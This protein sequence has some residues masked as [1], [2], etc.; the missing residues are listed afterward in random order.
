MDSKKASVAQAAMMDDLGNSRLEQL[1]TDDTSRDRR[2]TFA[3]RQQLSSRTFRQP[4]M[5][6]QGSA[7]ENSGAAR[8]KKAV[9]D[10]TFD[11]DDYRA[12]KGLDSIDD[13]N[14]HRRTREPPRRQTYDPAGNPGRIYTTAGQ[15][16]HPTL[17]TPGIGRGRGVGVPTLAR[18]S[19]QEYSQPQGRGHGASPTR[20]NQ[21]MPTNEHRRGFAFNALQGQSS[22]RPGPS[23]STVS[24]GPSV[25]LSQHRVRD[26]S[27][28]GAVPPNNTAKQF[29]THKASQSE[30]NVAEGANQPVGGSIKP[31]PPH[32][33]HKYALVNEKVETTPS[34]PQL[35]EQ[36]REGET[37]SDGVTEGISGI[38]SP[39]NDDEILHQDLS[40]EIALTDGKPRK[41]VPSAIT[42]YAK[43][44]IDT[45]FWEI[46]TEDVRMRGDIRYCIRPLITGPTVYLRRQ[47]GNADVQNSYIRFD[48]IV[49]AADFM[50]ELDR[51]RQQHLNSQG[52][53]FKE[54]FEKLQKAVEVSTKKKSPVPEHP[55]TEIGGKAVTEDF[56]HVINPR[57]PKKSLAVSNVREKQDKDLLPASNHL[58]PVTRAKVPPAV[59]SRGSARPG[60]GDTYKHKDDTKHINYNE[61]K[62]QTDSNSS[63][64][65]HSV[66]SIEKVPAGKYLSAES[67][68]ILATITN[69]DYHTMKKQYQSRV[70][71]DSRTMSQS[72]SELSPQIM[73][74]PQKRIALDVVMKW[75]RLDP[76]FSN[77]RFDEQKQVC[78]V[79][80]TNIR[81]GKK[82]VRSVGQLIKLRPDITR[83]PKEV[84]QFNTF[85]KMVGLSK[86][87]HIDQS[88]MDWDLRSERIAEELTEELMEDD[89]IEKRHKERQTR[90]VEEETKR[91]EAE[92]KR[93]EEEG[94]RAE[95]EK[96]QKAMSIASH[97]GNR[98]YSLVF[99]DSS[100]DGEENSGQTSSQD[101]PAAD[102][103]QPTAP[104]R[105]VAKSAN[106]PYHNSPAAH[107]LKESSSK[108]PTSRSAPNDKSLGKSYKSPW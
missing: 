79:A 52:E 45:V 58:T 12:V 31:P 92:K 17:P 18:G 14:A 78:A 44:N 64:L 43:P 67:L 35:P 32:I 81:R 8:W 69:E 88:L 77:L 22:T 73:D 42:L 6:P 55:K 97:K 62:S 27:E 102:T 106:T 51:L 87:H 37:I 89:E 3:P 60:W 15:G 29:A 108:P 76:R 93:A 25:L 65:G 40:A 75:M 38:P 5:Q 20:N 90:R 50:E 61:Q 70:D 63:I 16:Q 30:N 56:A 4:S 74:M 36:K 21:T 94:K 47:E 13:G 83:C 104:L 57:S 48:S 96:A 19:T 1:V 23:N 49:K 99:D 72:T 100:S 103:T 82:I 7:V 59:Q 71:K 34:V 54:T 85:W 39:S 80:Y 105:L 26:T 86:Q 66:E 10:G 9:N 98:L 41:S 84:A 33:R 95:E 107:G 53:I 68:R 101:A 46:K 91:V 28:M 11:D 2:G 24:R